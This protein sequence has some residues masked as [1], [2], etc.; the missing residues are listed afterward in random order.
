MGVIVLH[1]NNTGMGK[2]LVV[3]QGASNVFLWLLECLFVCAV[4]LFV[5]ISG[6]FLSSSQRRDCLKPLKLVVQVILF[7]EAFYLMSVIFGHN[8]LSLKHLIG[9]L[10]PCNWYV[11]IY[12]G[13]YL[14]SPYINVVLNYLHENGGYKRFIVII[15]ATYSVYPILVDIL[16][17]ARGKEYMGLS[18][19]GM[20]GSQAGYTIVNFI[21][22]YVLGDALR[23]YDDKKTIG[24][25]KVVLLMLLT[26]AVIFAW[27]YTEY[28]LIESDTALEY[29]DPLVIAEA[30]LVF[31]IFS[32]L[33]FQSRAVNALAK[34]SFTVYLIHGY[35]LPH[36]Q[37]QT[38]AAK[39]LPMVAAHLIICVLVI[40][41]VGLLVDWVYD[42]V[43]NPIWKSVDRKWV[44]H[45]KYA[46]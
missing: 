34:G 1:Y 44:K 12:V 18:T 17:V 29:C 14:I 7:N 36:I 33:K 21:I 2:G 4:N 19:V 8:D 13:L 26:L 15:C 25:R 20:Y 38:F 5:L 39:E 37:I 40:Y 28:H 27:T 45:R 30:V 32:R 46:V 22:M 43:M 41:A 42:K 11:I 31:M 6:Y 23:R 3:S 10:I 9:A 16:Q 24:T 35:F